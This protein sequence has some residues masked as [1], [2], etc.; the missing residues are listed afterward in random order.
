MSIPG[1]VQAGWLFTARI[2]HG[3]ARGPN[4]RLCG[5]F[6]THTARAVKIFENFQRKEWELYKTWVDVLYGLQT[7]THEWDT[8]ISEETD[9][10]GEE[11]Q[12]RWES[13]HP[14]CSFEDDESQHRD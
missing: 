7:Q 8:Q 2:P 14:A 5:Q 3:T 13:C 6:T 9:E 1:T 4:V 11:D 12:V 10:E